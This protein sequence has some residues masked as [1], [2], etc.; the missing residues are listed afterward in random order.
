MQAWNEG[1]SFRE[2][3]SRDAEIQKKLTPQQ[4]DRAFDVNRQLRNVDKIF[5]RVF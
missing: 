5:A 3:I 4:I 1:V 2:L